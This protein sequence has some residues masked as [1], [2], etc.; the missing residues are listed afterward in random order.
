MLDVEGCTLDDVSVEKL[1]DHPSLQVLNVRNTQVT[2]AC[3][4][5][6][7]KVMIGTRIIFN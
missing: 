7:R 1:T 3:V 6:L 4:A 2:E 5:R